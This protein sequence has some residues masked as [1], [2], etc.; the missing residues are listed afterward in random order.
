MGDTTHTVPETHLPAC[1]TTNTYTERANTT[2]VNEATELLAPQFIT[3]HTR[4]LFH[5]HINVHVR[6]Q[7]ACAAVVFKPSPRMS[8]GEWERKANSQRGPWTAID[9]LSWPLPYGSISPWV[10]TITEAIGINYG[11]VMRS[12][13]LNFYGRG[14]FVFGIDFWQWAVKKKNEIVRWT[15]TDNNNANFIYEYAE[16]IAVRFMIIIT[17]QCLYVFSSL[18]SIIY[19]YRV[20]RR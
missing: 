2:V 5:F 11:S 6:S 8:L 9:G 13:N 12:A 18:S 3:E 4:W 10:H 20:I 16:N 15:C 7:R 17:T 14:I 1:C 19:E